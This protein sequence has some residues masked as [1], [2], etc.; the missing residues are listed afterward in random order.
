V[1]RNG[2]LDLKTLR[3]TDRERVLVDIARTHV[4]LAGTAGEPIVVQWKK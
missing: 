3:S 4:E 2:R 1:L